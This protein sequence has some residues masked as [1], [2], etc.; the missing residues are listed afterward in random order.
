MVKLATTKSPNSYWN[1]MHI[2]R[3]VYINID[4]AALPS[5]FM[6][7]RSSSK[8]VVKRKDKTLFLI[9]N[10]ENNLLSV[11]KLHQVI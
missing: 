9:N 11:G 10:R 7:P 8:L 3:I 6:L 2:F 5:V 4:M 1:R